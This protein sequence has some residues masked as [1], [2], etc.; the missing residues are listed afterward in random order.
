[1]SLAR[2]SDRCVFR[3]S[4][5]AAPRQPA[6]PLRPLA[7]ARRS[8]LATYCASQGTNSGAEVLALAGEL[9]D[10]AQ[11]V[12][13]VAGVVAAAAEQHAVHA[14][15]LA[16]FAGQHPERVGELDLAA[17]SRRGLAQHAEHGRVAARSGR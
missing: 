16:G 6:V 9:D 4:L 2:I 3:H 7:V 17:A 13:L 12:E 11:V 5:M 10:R 14:A 8:A 1:M 15:A